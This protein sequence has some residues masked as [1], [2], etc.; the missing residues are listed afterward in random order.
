MAEK[1]FLYGI[2][3]TK[4][5]T[6]WLARCMRAHPDC[7]LP[8][9]KE[10]HYFDVVDQGPNLWNVDQIL[11]NR[12][13]ARTALAETTTG[14]ERAKA[15]R[16][17]VSI[18]QWLG[19]VAAGKA[20]DATYESLMRARLRS[21]H[22]CVADITP[23]YALLKSA[24]YARMAAL[25]NGQTRFLMILRD[26]VD[27]LCSNLSMTVARRVSKG[28][29]EAAVLDEL[30][31]KIAD[32]KVSDELAR[33][34]YARTL[35]RL[36]RAVPEQKRMVLFFEELFQEDTMA[37]ISDFI[38]LEV[39]LEVLEEKVN[40]GEGPALSDAKR[41][42]LAERLAPQY[43]DTMARFGRLPARWQANMSDV[44]N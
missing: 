13:A 25:N 11:R 20:D 5:G 28:A 6:T 8:P 22:R 10:T 43:E 41:A 26:P 38:G 40:A 35:M 32:G 21:H 19:L 30:V 24:T 44:V 3:A 39:P 29:D 42:L 12:E 36:E 17:V 27:R 7:A 14:E 18:D 31:G 16:R 1:V 34:D 2:G 15:A 9:V 33:S 4:A 37:Q 23:S